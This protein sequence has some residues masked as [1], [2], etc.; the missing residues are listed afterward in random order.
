MKV[1]NKPVTK[2]EAKKDFAEVVFPENI[3]K[4]PFTAEKYR[5]CENTVYLQTYMNKTFVSIPLRGELK[6]AFASRYCDGNLQKEGE[7]SVAGYAY[8]VITTSDYVSEGK[9]RHNHRMELAEDKDIDVVNG[10]K[11]ISIHKI[12]RS[13]AMD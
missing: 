3:Q 10:E 5:T 8:G 1:E 4:Y 2:K 6:Q 9:T 12:S 7:I 13:Y 11:V